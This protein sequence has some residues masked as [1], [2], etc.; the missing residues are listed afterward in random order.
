MSL[1]VYITIIIIALITFAIFI[2]MVI[3]IIDNICPYQAY[4]HYSAPSF[5]FLR[6]LVDIDILQH[7]SDRTGLPALRHSIFI[8]YAIYAMNWKTAVHYQT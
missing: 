6:F 8:C 3:I 4:A 1:Y 2:T 7:G 5:I